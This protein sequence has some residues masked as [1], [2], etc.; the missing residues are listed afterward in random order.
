MPTPTSYTDIPNE[1]TDRIEPS[2]S[3]YDVVVVGARAAGAASAMLMARNGLR[4]LAV[5]RQ[6]YGSD[7]FST[8]ALMRGAVRRLSDW[9]LLDSIIDDGTPL[10]TTT[11][12]T[13]G[14]ETMSLP[15]KPLPGEPG[16]IAPRRTSLDPV[17]VD[18]ARAAG[19]EVLHNTQVSS[20]VTNPQGRVVGVVL[21]LSD[22][23]EKT[24]AA[25]LVV[26]A[27]GLRS[28]VARKVEAPIT[29]TGNHASA[30]TMRYYTDL[31]VPTDTFHW[32][33]RPGI[34]GGV[35]PTTDDTV[36]V[37]A[38]MSPERFATEGRHDI[39]RIH[40]EILSTL[41]P[42]LGLAIE[43]AT[44]ATRTRSW[45]GVPGQFRKPHGPGW[46]LVGDAGYFKDPFAA[47]GIT[48]AFRDAE[49]LTEAVRTGDFAGYESRRNE[50]SEP[51]F[52]TLDQ[53]ASYRWDLDSLKGLHHDLSRA[54]R[55]E[56][57]A[58]AGVLQPA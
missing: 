24:I 23:T 1:N 11:N 15:V 32:L 26:G 19:A 20:I 12:F 42:E 38:A 45:P 27:D 58:T 39:D 28:F 13:Y 30:Y 44:P 3:H 22:G 37:F 7:T 35:I 52:E 51:L 57:K 53:I 10:I 47:H 8:H 34:G 18:G 4:V 48:D 46:A 31:D 2:F 17:L 16:L 54:M 40:T 21:A 14:D 49:L 9:G 33:Y 36:C 25:D 29:K 50:L 43:A 41:D 56:D 5:D 55:S 6:S